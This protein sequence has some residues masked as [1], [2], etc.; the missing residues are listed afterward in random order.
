LRA[1]RRWFEEDHQG[2]KLSRSIDSTGSISYDV[3]P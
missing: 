1:E 2:Q 3:C